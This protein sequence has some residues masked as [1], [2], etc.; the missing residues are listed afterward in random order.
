M[1]IGNTQSLLRLRVS[2]SLL[3]LRYYLMSERPHCLE[4]ISCHIYAIADI[5]TQT[6]ILTQADLRLS[7]RRRI[8]QSRESHWKHIHR[9]P[10]L[11]DQGQTGNGIESSRHLLWL[12]CSFGR[13][14]I[15]RLERV[16]HGKQ[17]KHRDA[18]HCEYHKCLLLEPPRIGQRM[19][20]HGKIILAVVNSFLDCKHVKEKVQ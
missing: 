11:N 18:K 1:S 2:M 3:G 6:D 7:W 15:R 8:L 14:S 13:I 17:R 20:A 12:F 16:P 5:L 4:I 10:K 19:L 9:D